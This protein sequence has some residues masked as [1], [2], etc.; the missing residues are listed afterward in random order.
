MKKPDSTNPVLYSVSTNIL[1]IEGVNLKDI[2]Q[3]TEFHIKNI[4]VSQADITESRFSITN[5]SADS[6][7]SKSDTFNIFSFFPKYKIDSVI[8]DNIAYQSINNDLDTSKLIKIGNLSLGSINIDTSTFSSITNNYLVHNINIS[9]QHVYTRL[10]KPEIE[11]RYDSLIYIGRSSIT[12]LGNLV[13]KANCSPPQSDTIAKCDIKIESATFNNLTPE[14]LIAEDGEAI[15]V[16]IDNWTANI[17][18][19]SKIGI[20]KGENPSFKLSTKLNFDIVDIRNGNIQISNADTNFLNVNKVDFSTTELT[21][22]MDGSKYSKIINY[23]EINSSFDNLEFSPEANFFLKINNCQLDNNGLNISGFSFLN[24]RKDNTDISLSGFSITGFDIRRVINNKEFIAKNLIINKPGISHTIYSHSKSTKNDSLNFKFLRQEIA[25]G[26]GNQLDKVN[27]DNITF[28]KGNIDINSTFNET[29]FRSNFA[30]HIRNTRFDKKDALYNS[31]ISVESVRLLLKQTD[32]RSKDISMKYETIIIDS[33]LDKVSFIN[34]F[35]LSKPGKTANGNKKSEFHAHIPRIDIIGPDFNAYLYHPMSFSSMII[36][37]PNI[38]LL[39]HHKKKKDKKAKPLTGDIPFSFFKEYIMLNDGKI[40]ITFE[41]DKDTTVIKTENISATWY[42]NVPKPATGV[43]FSAHE[44]MHKADVT[45]SDLI[46]SNRKTKISV[47]EVRHKVNDTK[48][49]IEGFSQASYYQKSEIRELTDKVVIP[50][51]LIEHPVLHKRMGEL[52]NID[53][54]KIITPEVDIN[55]YQTHKKASPAK[56]FN[57]KDTTLRP[58]FNF[59]GHFTIDSTKIGN[60]HFKYFSIDTNN[61][62]LDLTRM[63]IIVKGLSIDSSLFTSHKSIVK[64]M[65]IIFYKRKFITKDSMYFIKSNNVT[66]SYKDNRLVL[67]SVYMI[68]RYGRDEFFE[69]AVYQTDRISIKGKNIEIEGIDFESILTDRIYHFNKVSV[70]GIRMIDHRD[71]RYKRKPGVYKPMPQTALRNLPLKIIID[72]L[73]I[74]NSYLL[75]GE[76]VDKSSI[77][78]EVYFTDFNAK[79]QNITNV[80]KV[81][82]QNYRMDISLATNLMGDAKLTLNMAFSLTDSSDYFE[83]S[84][85]L[86]YFDLTKMNSMTENL[87]GLTIKSGKGILDINGIKGDDKLATGELFFK[88]KNFKLGLYNRKKAK[89]VSG[90]VS[91]IVSFLVNDIKLASNN[92]K[93]LGKPR[94]GEVYFERDSQKSILNYIWKSSMSG[95]LTTLGISNKKQKEAMKEERKL[96]KDAEKLKKQLEKKQKKFN[97]PR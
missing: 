82:N 23:K 9:S 63:S 91:P 49:R 67:D 39:I 76:Y 1:E 54:S 57:F 90:I 6:I 4:R 7:G 20:E 31:E 58:I 36:D 18:N 16:Y 69:K 12:H 19:L 27:I 75:Y 41:S 78:G 85:H 66:Y 10:S 94:I 28:S 42:E 47:K 74:N 15:S 84:G 25:R 64:D 33:K 46:L 68:P 60:L 55:F 53:F 44:Q 65:N 3:Q 97:K 37:N 93:P 72:S 56:H 51:I 80:T 35:L 89:E 81:I 26:I 52:A 8:F 22:F 50:E 73:N 70:N 59:L 29:T 17:S 86:N 32:F 2:L 92:P 43:S 71:K 30:L 48:I 38:N 62:P 61:K 88:Y 83:Y 5:S 87:F 45:I 24:D 13:V 96:S 11:F 34:S 14:T 77:P 21:I 79:I 95:L 40:I